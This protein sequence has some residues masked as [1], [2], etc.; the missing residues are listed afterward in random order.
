MGSTCGQ[1][2]VII[3]DPYFD[4]TNKIPSSEQ[5]TLD[6]AIDG[7][8]HENSR[9]ACCVNVRP[10]LNEMIVVVANNRGVDGDYFSGKDPAA[11]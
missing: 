5:K 9:L 1:C 6:R 2:H 10:E 8:S 7:S 11:F 4:K 3:S